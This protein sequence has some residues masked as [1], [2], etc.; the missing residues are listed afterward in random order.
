MEQT[1]TLTEAEL[2][3][4]RY[5]LEQE[6]DRLA[7]ELFAATERW[8]V[9]DKQGLPETFAF[10]CHRESLAR[11]IQRVKDVLEKI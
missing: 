5:S 10:A 3:I 9:A 8:I 6:H 4:V 11:R 7:K 1:L 2:N